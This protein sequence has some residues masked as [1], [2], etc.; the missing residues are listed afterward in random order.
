MKFFNII[1]GECRSSSRVH[2]C[3]NPRTE[4]TLWD[5]PLASTDDLDEAVQAAKEA[6]K[7]WGKTTTAHRQQLLKQLGEKLEEHRQELV[8]I[9]IQETGKSVSIVR[10]CRS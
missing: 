2:Q 5:A 8:D 9:L 7:S 10:V 6:Q 1:N 4:E 3:V